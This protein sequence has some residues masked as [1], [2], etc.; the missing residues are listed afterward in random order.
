MSDRRRPQLGRWLRRAFDNRVLAG[1]V[2]VPTDAALRFRRGGRIL[3]GGEN[4]RVWK[5]DPA[6]SVVYVW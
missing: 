6:R 5:I 2:T 1:E 3:L 4:Y